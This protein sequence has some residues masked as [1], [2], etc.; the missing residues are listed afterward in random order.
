MTARRRGGEKQRWRVVV[1]LEGIKAFC[2]LL[3]MRL[4]KSRPLVNPAL[5]EREL[6]P[7]AAQ[8]TPEVVQQWDG[9]DTPPIP[10]SETS[11][12]L[13]WAMP[14]TGLNLPSLPDS[15]DITDFL[16]RKVVNADDIKAPKQLLHRM[17]TFQAQLAEVIWV[18]RPVLYALA[19]QKLAAHNAKVKG[20]YGRLSTWGPWLAGVS[21]EIA[22][23]RLAKR[24]LSERVAGGLR[25]LTGLEREELGKR[26]WGLGWWAMRGAFYEDYTG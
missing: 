11:N 19:M 9:M 23:R 3:L 8:E 21:L 10:R 4:T 5:P 1:L 15:S 25:G 2:R 20:K 22:A 26:G 14:R 12:D 16:L 13:I 18:L 24:D 7:R 17:T 6:D